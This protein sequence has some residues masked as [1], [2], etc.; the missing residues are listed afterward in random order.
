M[1]TVGAA[2]RRPEA[3]APADQ[4]I[5]LLRGALDVTAAPAVRERLIGMLHDGTHRLILD[6][7]RVLSCDQAG[8]AVLIGTQRRAR[9]LGITVCLAAPTLPVADLLRATGLDR[10]FTIYPDLPS[11][12]RPSEAPRPA[13]LS[14]GRQR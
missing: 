6:L 3:S 9:L 10:R 8:L 12:L 13:P 2:S 11:A 14:G 7:S 1:I 4:A 5:V